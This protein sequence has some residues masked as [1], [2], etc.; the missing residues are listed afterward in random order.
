MRDAG[1]TS[2]KIEGRMKTAYYAAAVTSVYRRAVAL[3]RLGGEYR[4]PNELLAELNKV[5][6]REY[7]TGFYFGNPYGDGQNVRSSDYIRDYKHVGL[8]DKYQNNRLYFNQRNKFFA[9][10]ELD[11][12]TPDNGSIIIKADDLRDADGNLLESAP[13]AEQLVSVK[14]D[15]PIPK[16][17]ML[18]K[19]IHNS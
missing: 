6:H 10:D 9:G 11:V 2:F 13:H 5:S 17:S 1:I 7:S 4:A 12:L 14:C 16:W 8:A 19:K 15:T 18:R 3:L